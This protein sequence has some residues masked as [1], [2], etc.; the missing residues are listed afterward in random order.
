MP[1]FYA[2]HRSLIFFFFLN[3]DI[4]V[5]YLPSTAKQINKKISILEDH[6]FI[7]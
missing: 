7:E 3:A 5:K 6:D 4:L 2:V 1:E